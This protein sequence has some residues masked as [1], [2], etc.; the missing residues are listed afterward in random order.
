[1]TPIDKEARP[2]IAITTLVF[3]AFFLPRVDNVPMSFVNVSRRQDT[4]ALRP[5]RHSGRINEH[6]AKK[7]ATMEASVAETAAAKGACRRQC[8][9]GKDHSG[10][11]RGTDGRC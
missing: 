6:S 11:W 3:T 8:G 4:A 7:G 5:Q 9:R 2:L 10:D 1:M